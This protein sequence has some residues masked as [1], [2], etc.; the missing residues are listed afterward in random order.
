M[1]RAAEAQ[2]FFAEGVA[3]HRAGNLLA[4]AGRFRDAIRC[5]PGLAEAHASLGATL[6]ALGQDAA[7]QAELLP[8]RRV[9][10]AEAGG[11]RIM[12]RERPGRMIAFVDDP[13]LHQ[14]LLYRL[15]GRPRMVLI[16]PGAAVTAQEA[17]GYAYVIVQTG[18]ALEGKGW[19]LVQ[20]GARLNVYVPQ[21]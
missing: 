1:T 9:Q 7:W 14:N 10:G 4:A 3:C 12:A 8:D 5:V 2:R 16:A 13:N 17:R 18:H 11:V 20:P 19:R 6:L 15:E 21:N